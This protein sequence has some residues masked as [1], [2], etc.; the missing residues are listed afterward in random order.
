MWTVEGNVHMGLGWAEPIPCI[1]AGFGPAHRTRPDPAQLKK[2]KNFIFKILCLFHLLLYVFLFNF[3]LY[4]ILRNYESSIKI[5]GFCQ[6]F[7]N[8]KKNWKKKKCFCA[9]GQVSQ[10]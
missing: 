10:S 9:Y 6:I 2:I 5:P 8:A 4:F 1:W 7:Q 3:G